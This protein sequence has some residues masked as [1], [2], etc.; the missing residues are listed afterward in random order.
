MLV[1]VII[2]AYNAER[3]IAECLFAV[4]QQSWR[5]LEIIVV[6]DGST[7][8]TADIVRSFS[9]VH[10]IHQENA[11]PAA[12]RN[13]GA[14]HAKGEWVAFTDSD[15][16]PRADW[17]AKLMEKAGPGV[18]AVGG[19]YGIAN[20]ASPLARLVHYEIQ[21]RHRIMPDRVNFLG[22]FNVAYLRS[23]FEEIGGFDETFRAASAEDNDL[24]YRLYYGGKN[25]VFARDSIVDHY[26]PEQ[27]MPSLRTQRRHGFWRVRLHQKHRN[28]ATRGDMYAGFTELVSPAFALVLLPLNFVLLVYI[29]ATFL[30]G[31]QPWLALLCFIVLQL[32]MALIHAMDTFIVH[33][34]GAGSAALLFPCLR[35]LRDFYR[36]LGLAQGVIHYY[37][38]RRS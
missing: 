10:Y 17:I 7:D 36:G 29:V 1:S 16:V 22:S 15:C 18:H 30:S 3:T 32:L 14:A 33:A 31:S 38:L 9:G 21:M 27:L 12:A 11:G 6:D 24:S 23:A 5:D 13:R 20:P 34:L 26:H 35:V 25:L 37:V 4:Q 2:P 28:R 8:R 19:T